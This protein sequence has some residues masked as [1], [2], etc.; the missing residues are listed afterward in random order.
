M[1]VMSGIANIPL[2]HNEPVLSYAP[3]SAERSTLKAAL[4]SLGSQSEEIPVVV[5]GREIR[6]GVTRHVVSP[7]CHGRVL[8]TVHHADPATVARAADAADEARRE[9]AHWR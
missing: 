7:H 3:G 1:S 6:T 5:G 8:A 4:D 9:W 2:P